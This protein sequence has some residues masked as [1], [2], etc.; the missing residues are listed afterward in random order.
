MKRFLLAASLGAVGCGGSSTMNPPVDNPMDVTMATG[1]H[2]KFVANTLKAPTQRADFAIDLN[3]DGKTDNQLGNIIGALSGQGLDA[4]MGIDESM[5]KG[6]VILLFDL[7]AADL[8]KSDAA[9]V[10]V[11]LGKSMPNPDFTG[12]GSFT[13]NAAQPPGSFFGRITDGR[14]KT[15]NPVTTKAPVTVN[16]IL[17]LAGGNLQ[18]SL[19]GASV[20]FD[21]ASDS[22]LVKGQINGSIKDADVKKQIIP[23]VAQLLSDQVAKG[24]GGVGMDGGKPTDGGGMCSGS[25]QQI[26]TLFDTGGCGAAKANDGKIEAFEVENNQIIKNVLAPDVQIFDAA[27]GYKPN[28]DNATRDSLSLGLSFTAVKASF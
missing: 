20:Q 16:M 21:I 14:L 2:Y 27:G 25:A 26:K 22:S 9:G 5:M 10:T 4:Q 19:N 18:L 23:V 24:C 28:K 8:K 13:V 6:E 15:N 17:P 3:G 7:Q 12:K 1:N 11:S